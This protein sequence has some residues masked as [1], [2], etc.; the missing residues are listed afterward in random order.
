MRSGGELAGTMLLGYSREMIP[1]FNENGYL[2]PGVH[3]ATIEEV[4][5]RF[6]SDS[7]LRKVQ[8]ESLKWLL[9]LAI[10]A[11]IS[12]VVV[13]GSFTTDI[14]EPND[15]DCALLMGVDFPRDKVAEAEL[16]AGLPFLEIN[17]LDQTDFDLLVKQFFATDR[18]ANPKGMV[19]II[20]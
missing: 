14:S 7:E 11:G 17:L 10:R 20:L 2:P 5:T 15:V 3:R 9:D 4:G 19:E 8:I 12:R 6:G 13:N 16:L 18:K 1:A